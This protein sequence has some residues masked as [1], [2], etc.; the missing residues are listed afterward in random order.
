MIL[1]AKIFGLTHSEQMMAAA[2]AGWHNG[3]SKRYF[4]NHAFRTLLSE[5]E[6]KIVNLLSL[7]LAL[8]ESMDYSES[9]KVL[10][11]DF[12]IEPERVL[13]TLKTDGNA[14]I[15]RY[16][17]EQHQIWFTKAFGRELSITF[18]RA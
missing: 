7:L 16:Q 11:M 2:V 1:N 12:R 9:G 17:L 18:K 4:K 13:L 8:S 14:P 6:W 15:E 3:V 10:A 5:E